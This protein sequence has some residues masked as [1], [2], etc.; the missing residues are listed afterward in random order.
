MVADHFHIANRG[1]LLPGK[2]ADIAVL[3]L[4][5]YSFPTEGEVSPLR[6]LEMARGVEWVM[7]NGAFVLENGEVRATHSGR[8]LRRGQG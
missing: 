7:V 5:H 4:E 2:Y 6:P 1:R 8:V 3:D